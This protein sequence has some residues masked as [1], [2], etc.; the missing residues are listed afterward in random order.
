VGATTV[1][2]TAT[3]RSSAV[4][5]QWRTSP[6]LGTV[7]GDRHR[8]GPDDL[9]A[10]ADG[11]TG[12]E[13]GVTGVAGEGDAVT[14]GPAAAAGEDEDVAAPPA[15]A[16]PALVAGTGG[17]GRRCAGLQGGT[18]LADPLDAPFRR[19][20]RAARVATSGPD[21]AGGLR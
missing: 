6:R 21:R 1:A 15:P 4:R 2:E 14:G 9:A 8:P 12:I 7:D 20:R 10:R 11:I 13:E 18:R 3:G 17:V 16:A 19:T 5:D